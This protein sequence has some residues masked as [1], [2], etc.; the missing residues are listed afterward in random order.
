[1]RLKSR[2]AEDACEFATGQAA[3]T[4]NFLGYPTSPTEMIDPNPLPCN[5]AG[6]RVLIYCHA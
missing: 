2:R 3:N 4:W 1:M 6:S 5:M